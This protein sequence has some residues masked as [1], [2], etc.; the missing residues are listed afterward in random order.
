MAKTISEL[1]EMFDPDFNDEIYDAIG[2][3]IRD[4]AVTA[5]YRKILQII[6]DKFKQQ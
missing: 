3:A 1:E 6:A 4:D 5:A 2:E